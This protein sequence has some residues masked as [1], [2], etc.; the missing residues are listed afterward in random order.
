MPSTDATDVELV[1]S[2]ILSNESGGGG[3]HGGGGS[4]T[5]LAGVVGEC[6]ERAG[7]IIWGLGSLDSWAI[8]GLP[9]DRRV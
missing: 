5:L 7:E 3:L 6:P 4:D 2:G 9:V 8:G 1:V